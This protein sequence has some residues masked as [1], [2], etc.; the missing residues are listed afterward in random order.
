MTKSGETVAQK[1]PKNSVEL[2]AQPAGLLVDQWIAVNWR[3]QEQLSRTRSLCLAV[4]GALVEAATHG[5]KM[6]VRAL[7]AARADANVQDLVGWLVGRLVG[8]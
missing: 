5:S 1:R 6:A 3:K 4:P 2:L 7:L 8:W